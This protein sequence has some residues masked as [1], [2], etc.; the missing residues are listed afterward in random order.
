MD[1]KAM[2]DEVSAGLDSAHIRT[3]CGGATP[4][5]L[6][7]IGYVVTSIPE[8]IEGFANSLQANWDG[9][10]IHDPL[11]QVYVAFLS[12]CTTTNPMVELVSPAGSESPVIRF[13]QRGGGLHHLCYEVD[14]LDLQ[15]EYACSVGGLIVKPA[16]PAV[17]FG[18]RRIAWVFTRSELLLEYLER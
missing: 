12:S 4:A 13:L 8:V 14:N 15:L 18:G 7:H 1:R 6:H 3:P 2:V 10:L 17:A 5:S 16:V 11:Q 9:K